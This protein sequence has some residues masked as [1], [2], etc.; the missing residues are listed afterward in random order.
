MGKKGKGIWGFF[1]C[2]GNEPMTG[3][4]YVVE[5]IPI[6]PAVENYCTGDDMANHSMVLDWLV[7]QC[8]GRYFQNWFGRT[9]I[10]AEMD[11]AVAFKM[12][13]GGSIQKKELDD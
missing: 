10:F 1:R 12:K 5:K 8:R 7:N 3:T 9:V 11:D 13:F 4:V 2:K 6:A